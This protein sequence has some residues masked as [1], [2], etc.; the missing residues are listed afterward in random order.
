MD[1]NDIVKNEDKPT[2]AQ[3]AYVIKR[4]VDHAREGGSYRYLIYDRLGYGPEAYEPLLVAGGM[5][6]SNLC[7]IEQDDE[8]MPFISSYQMCDVIADL[9]EGRAVV[10]YKE[11]LE[12]LGTREREVDNQTGRRFHKGDRVMVAYVCRPGSGTLQIMPDAWRG[13]DELTGDD[14]E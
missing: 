10:L 13:V 7:P 4:M 6:F 1:I 14:H 2:I 9:G 11:P 12:A 3:C 5:D 8:W